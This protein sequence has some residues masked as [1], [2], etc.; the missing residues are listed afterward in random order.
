MTTQLIPNSFTSCVLPM[1]MKLSNSRLY[2]SDP[3]VTILWACNRGRVTCKWHS[4]SWNSRIS[5]RVSNA[6]RMSYVHGITHNHDDHCHL[7]NSCKAIQER[8]KNHYLP[9]TCYFFFQCLYKGS[10]FF[11]THIIKLFFLLSGCNVH[12]EIAQSHQ[13][14]NIE[15]NRTYITWGLYMI[16]LHKAPYDYCIGIC[17]Y[18]LCHL[19]G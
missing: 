14:I 3:W 7:S 18:L 13:G 8:R 12:I 15:T 4:L 19:K 9:L 11:N 2:C 17:W 6:P 5:D 1:T 10:Y 16:S